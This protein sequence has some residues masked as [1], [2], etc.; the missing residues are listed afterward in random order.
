MR[1]FTR[2]A[3]ADC[4]SR[5]PQ[6]RAQKRASADGCHWHPRAGFFILQNSECFNRKYQVQLSPDR[7]PVACLILACIPVPATLRTGQNDTRNPAA[8]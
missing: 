7:G 2:H 5:R 3:P 1:D 6:K 8:L 4:L